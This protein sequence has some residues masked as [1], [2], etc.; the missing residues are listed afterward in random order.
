MGFAVSYPHV[1]NLHEIQNGEWLQLYFLIWGET[2][3]V[4]FKSISLYAAL[5]YCVILSISW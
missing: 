1:E 2:Q 3:F 5:K 4:C